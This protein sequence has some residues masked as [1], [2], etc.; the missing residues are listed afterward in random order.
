MIEIREIEADDYAR[1]YS[2]QT[3]YLDQESYAQFVSRVEAYPDLY[4]TAWNEQDLVGVC[5]ASPSA[6]EQGTIVIEGIA[7]SLDESKAY[8][9]KGYGSKLIASLEKVILQKGYHK[10]DVG[11]ADDQKIEHFYLKNGFQPYQ[12]VAKN[13]Q[14]QELARVAV[15]NYEH[16]QQIQQ[17][18][19]QEHQASEVIFI[20]A[21]DVT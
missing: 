11:S 2:F 5:Y 6:R 10:L 12:L 19:R 17:Q 4:L 18:L 1:V 9:R 13:E 21:K 20:L 16:G 3:E 15:D 14:H 7:I 8:A